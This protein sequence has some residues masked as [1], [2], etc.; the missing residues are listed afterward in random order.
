MSLV[1][2]TPQT[3]PNAQKE[4][5]AI[6]KFC[7]GPRMTKEFIKKHCKEN[8][9]Y[10]TPY[11]NDVLYLHF[12]GFSEIE[13][14]EEYTGLRCLWLE[15][16]GLLKISGLDNQ[17]ELRSL[18][19]HYNLIRKIENVG[20]LVFLDTL[21][22]SHN[23]VRRIENLD[24]IKTLHSLNL[25]NNY[26]EHLEDVEHLELLDEVSVLDV[27]NNHIEDPLIVKVLGNMKS[28]RVL[29]MMGNPVVRKIP[30]Y[31]KTM[32]ITC[33]DL[34]YLDDRPVFPRDRAC[35]EAWER[36]GITEESAER[37]RWIQRERQRIMDSVNALVRM[38]DERRQEAAAA[39][40]HLDSGMG[41]S[42]H[43][44]E[45]EADTLS[46]IVPNQ[47][48]EEN[49]VAENHPEKENESQ[50][51][52]SVDS[53]PQ[54]IQN[55]EN[56]PEEIK[57]NQ[58]AMIFSESEDE[59]EL[60]LSASSSTTSES[61]DFMRE[62]QPDPDEYIE[63][64]ERIF[65]FEPKGTRRSR[66]EKKKLI[67]EINTEEESVKQD[68]NNKDENDEKGDA[69]K[70]IKL[71]ENVDDNIDDKINY[72]GIAKILQEEYD[73]NNKEIDENNEGDVEIEKSP[74]EIEENQKDNEIIEEKKEDVEK[75]KALA[76]MLQG[77]L[78]SESFF[79]TF[80]K[81]EIEE[82]KEIHDSKDSD[83]EIVENPEI[84]SKKELKKEKKMFEEKLKK[85]EELKQVVEE[86][87][88]VEEIDQRSL[89]EI[90]APKDENLFS[91]SSSSSSS[92]SSSSDSEENEFYYEDLDKGIEIECRNTKFKEA[93]QDI[94]DKNVKIEN[95]EE[96]GREIL[97]GIQKE[98]SL[99]DVKELLKWNLP[100]NTENRVILKPIDRSIPN[101][102]QSLRLDSIDTYEL[103]LDKMERKFDEEEKV[104]KL[105]QPSKLAEAAHKYIRM[106]DRREHID[107]NE[108]TTISNSLQL[109]KNFP[110]F[111]HVAGVNV[112]V[113][114]VE[115]DK[116]EEIL[117]IKASNNISN[118]REDMRAF[119]RQVEELTSVFDRKYDLL[120]Q[121]YNEYWNEYVKSQ[122]KEGENDEEKKEH[123]KNSY[124]EKFLNDDENDG[125]DDDCEKNVKKCIDK[126]EEKV[127]NIINEIRIGGGY[128][129]ARNEEV[130]KDE[131][132]KENDDVA[133][134]GDGNLEEEYV[135]DLVKKIEEEMVEDEIDNEISG[136]NKDINED[137]NE[138]EN[139]KCG[140]VVVERN[141]SCTLE[142]Q[143]ATNN[144]ENEE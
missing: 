90:Y 122:E 121:T 47:D 41:T 77:E 120:I 2:E 68:E 45:S 95:I 64:R 54:V 101:S 25:A 21:N 71:I 7:K 65:D 37:Q 112:E 130:F 35:A 31:R 27:S 63:Y 13:N 99:N 142:M 72:K 91:S 59:E 133:N 134:D 108:E 74:E 118:L 66:K 69:E 19:L 135:D 3:D 129:Y 86:L 105:K 89:V 30:S 81:E 26:L 43:D 76:K 140:I 114:N 20:H 131:N 4:E 128:K 42:V 143:L 97:M 107:P 32:I 15:N 33:K 111:Q 119:N 123:V 113:E 144:Q 18:F 6:S 56:N 44:S 1:V 62:H 53:E 14:L 61:D 34:R 80:G 57:I 124:I 24:S 106:I 100:I 132:N 104:R 50:E 87:K 85:D 67:V 46:E 96:S 117:S 92:T 75:I 12:K 102:T 5:S 138:D 103:V 60:S 23:Q 11:L 115:E 9:L 127:G 78:E 109:S 88:K 125:G 94:I 98:Q 83:E 136:E 82:S 48:E 70:E 28:L 139:T 55:I 10:A 93:E 39:A 126:K 79:W 110:V 141:V 22:L 52:K 137:K 8:K 17:T 116:K 84:K 73:D 49:N 58:A 29:N 40:A 38:R 16:N 51:E 36:G